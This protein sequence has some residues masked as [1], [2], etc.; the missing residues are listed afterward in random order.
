[1]YRFKYPSEIGVEITNQC[2][3]DCKHCINNSSYDDNHYLEYDT[4]NKIIRYMVERGIVCLD[5]SGG[6]PLLHKDINKIIETAYS[7]DLTISIATNGYLLD[8]KKIDFFKNKNVSVRI[9]FDGYDDNTY[10]I[11]RGENKFDRVIKNISLAVKKGL[12][13]SLVTVLHSKNVKNAKE[14]IKKAKELGVSKIRFMM[15]VNQGRGKNSDLKML[16]VGDWKY[17]L[18]NHRKWGEEYQMEVCIDSPLMAIT[19]KMECPCIVGKLCIVI[20]ANGDV[21]PCALLNKKIGNI[22]EK[23]IDEIWKSPII[24]ELNNTDL[25]NEE[26]KKCK[27]KEK[28]AGGCRGLAYLMKG[29]YLCKDPYC[30]IQSQN[31]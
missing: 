10:K 7:N 24:D 15:Y 12:K 27:Y 4:I 29:D 1:M 30:W 18:E 21:I 23:S 8:E 6:E 17:I 19:E 25:L 5:L 22:F 28:C 20:K 9:S 31:R 3:F 16:S 26:C 2:N 14:F 13:I 11:I